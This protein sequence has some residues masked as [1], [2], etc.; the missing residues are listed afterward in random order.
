MTVQAINKSG[1]RLEVS[2][3]LP[4]TSGAALLLD[5][6][7]LEQLLAATLSIGGVLAELTG[8]GP[9]VH[10]AGLFN[11][12]DYHLAPDGPRLIEINTNA[13]GAFLQHAILEDAR[14]AATRLCGA[15]DQR[16]VVAPVSMILSTWASLRPG[17]RL[18]S[19]AVVDESPELQPLYGDMLGAVDALRATGVQARVSDVRSLRLES[20]RLADPQGPIDLVYNRSTDFLLSHPASAALLQAWQ[21]GAA[22]VAPNPEV[23]RAYA[24]KR[25]LLRLAAERCN[26]R[27]GLEAV[28]PTVEVTAG[29]AQELW[30]ERKSLVFKPFNGFASRGVLLGAKI[31]RGRFESLL[32]GGYIAQ[33]YAPPITHLAR[34]GTETARFKADIRVW[35]HGYTPWYA[36]ARLYRGQVSGMRQPGEGFAPIIWLAPHAQGVRC[37][38]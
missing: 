21:A 1:F 34:V 26:G 18:A 6:A 11:S 4:L 32:D 22:V 28:L 12:F 24:D 9:E 31:T 2:S 27:A 37:S 33:S 23:Y 25:L 35:T 30:R 16:E 20:G 7:R 8:A 5:R 36:A 38:A 19:V 3:D 29:A 15:I 13:G 14:G 17:R 10:A